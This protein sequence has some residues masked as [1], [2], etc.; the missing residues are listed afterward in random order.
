MKGTRINI[1]GLATFVLA[2]T[3]TVLAISGTVL[4]FSPR[5]RVANWTGWSFLGI[6]KES[7]GS[8]HVVV[9]LT[10]L[11]VAGLHLF[12][13]WRVFLRYLHV[14]S[15]P[16]LHLKKEFAAALL[17]TATITAGTLQGIPPFNLVSGWGESVKDYWETDS[18][19]VP[20]PHAE[21]STVEEF[22]AKTGTTVDDLR[23]KLAAKNIDIGD[24]KKSVGEVAKNHGVS[25]Q[26]LFTKAP[27]NPGQGP[28]S[29][30]TGMGRK[31]LRQVC[32]DEGISLDTALQT[33]RSSG[34]QV[35]PDETMRDIAERSG[36]NPH[37]LAALMKPQS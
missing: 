4:Y 10:F 6:V 37:E 3:F 36:K 2:M 19:S 12:L 13:N 33:L 24:G 15:L 29:G 1:R 8:V 32:A 9:A 21:L 11:A 34:I 26:A 23:A 22:A 27:H 28:S 17:L 16:G 5:G 18:A 14:P 25:P 30:G 35:E 31:T 20:Y 7:W